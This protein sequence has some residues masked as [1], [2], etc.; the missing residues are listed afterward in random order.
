MQKRIDVCKIIEVLKTTDARTKS[1]ERHHI[2]YHAVVIID[3]M[4][5]LEM[6]GFELG[7]PSKDG[8]H[9]GCWYKAVSHRQ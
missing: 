3:E 1:C 5:Y 7:S 8:V 6:L 4:L 9:P 2:L